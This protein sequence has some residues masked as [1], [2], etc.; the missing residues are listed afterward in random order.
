MRQKKVVATIVIKPGMTEDEAFTL[1]DDSTELG[2]FLKFLKDNP[3]ATYG[4]PKPI[5]KGTPIVYD[6]NDPPEGDDD[7]GSI[8][9]D[10]PWGVA[11]FDAL[12]AAN[13]G[14]KTGTGIP[15]GPG[16]TD[17][18]STYYDDNG[19]VKVTVKTSTT[20]TSKGTVKRG[21]LVRVE[22]SRPTRQMCEERGSAG[23]QV[24]VTGVIATDE[25]VSGI[26]TVEITWFKGEHG[27]HYF[28]I[29]ANGT[30]LDPK[31]TGTIEAPVIGADWIMN[32]W[33]GMPKELKP[34]P[35]TE[36]E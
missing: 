15:P 18:D 3:D 22:T 26:N 24:L 31:T 9:L 11:L 35:G 23:A 33:I 32:R 19:K 27:G 7:L 1:F 36:V 28:V 6:P 30:Q 2:Q 12:A 13:H 20:T 14:T 16:L 4:L 21:P 34:T 8:T 29:Y 5:P 10:R 17:G 25:M